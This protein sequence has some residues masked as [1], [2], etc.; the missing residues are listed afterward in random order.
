MRFSRSDFSRPSLLVALGRAPGLSGLL[1][2]W[3]PS[4]LLISIEPSIVERGRE[5]QS[6]A[7][8]GAD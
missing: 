6:G 3:P 8:E 7:L 5:V 2:W 1:L 4:P